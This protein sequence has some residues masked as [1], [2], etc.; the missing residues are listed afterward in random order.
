MNKPLL[1]DMGFYCFGITF[2]KACYEYGGLLIGAAGYHGHAIH[3]AALSDYFQFFICKKHWFLLGP[4]ES[5]FYC[6]AKGLLSTRM[7]AYKAHK[8]RM[9]LA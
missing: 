6:M 7:H 9:Q 4:N 5:T 1:T 3:S 2:C 8:A